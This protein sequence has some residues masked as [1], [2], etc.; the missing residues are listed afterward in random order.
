MFRR[1][2]AVL[3]SLVLV[4]VSSAIPSQAQSGRGRQLRIQGTLRRESIAPEAT[5]GPTDQKRDG[6]ISG[7][8]PLSRKTKGWIYNSA[9]ANQKQDDGEYHMTRADKRAGWILLGLFA[10][11]GAII[12]SED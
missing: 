6:G 1:Y 12:V 3:V 7:A 8:P 11:W 9:A 4:V 2:S 5:E 10:L